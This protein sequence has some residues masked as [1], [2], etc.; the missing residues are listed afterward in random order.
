MNKNNIQYFIE[1]WPTTQS[2]WAETLYFPT[3]QPIVL[4]TKDNCEEVHDLLQNSDF[5]RYYFDRMKWQWQPR[6]N[7][8]IQWFESASSNVS[9]SYFTPQHTEYNKQLFDWLLWPIHSWYPWNKAEFQKL[10]QWLFAQHSTNPTII[11]VWSSKQQVIDAAWKLFTEQWACVVRIADD[12]YAPWA[13]SGV[14]FMTWVDDVVNF[15]NQIDSRSWKWYCDEGWNLLTDVLIE[16][17]FI[18]MWS[19]SVTWYI[20]PQW[21]AFVFSIN[22]QYLNNGQFFA[23]TNILTTSLDEKQRQDILEKSKILMQH[24]AKKYPRSSLVWFDVLML[25]DWSFKFIECNFRETGN[26]IPFM[27]A[28]RATDYRYINNLDQL[29]RYY[30]IDVSRTSP[31]LDIPK[32]IEQREKKQNNKIHGVISYGNQWDDNSWLFDLV[33]YYDRNVLSDQQAKLAINELLKE[34][35]HNVFL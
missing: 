3:T 35:S 31:F 9:P 26:T 25:K 32:T 17:K 24:I 33:I 13:W 4:L 8:A 22:D 11:P 15:I 30:V 16:K 19:P 7:I 18:G 10:V 14:L 2:W 27:T 23:W 21:V 28:H 34:F 5:H 1:W 6:N 29:W 12:A 20:D